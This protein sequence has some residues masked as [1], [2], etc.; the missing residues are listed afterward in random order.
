MNLN[1]AE[2]RDSNADWAATDAAQVAE[3]SYSLA[4][5]LNEQRAGKQRLHVTNVV[6]GWLLVILLGA[7]AYELIRW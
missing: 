2:Q 4:N 7:A 3:A 1:D 5:A 6:C